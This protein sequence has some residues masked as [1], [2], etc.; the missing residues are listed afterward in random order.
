MS[1]SRC[2]ASREGQD[3]RSGHVLDIRRAIN[4]LDFSL[5]AGFAQLDLAT[6]PSVPTLASEPVTGDLSADGAHEQQQKEEELR[7]C[8]KAAY[9]ADLASFHDSELSRNMLDRPVVRVSLVSFF[10]TRVLTSANRQLRSKVWDPLPTTRWGT[11]FYTTH[12]WML[13][14]RAHTLETSIWAQ[15]FKIA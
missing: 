14:C 8:R 3:P 10:E 13:H 12:V 4:S 15:P 9:D 1:L 2:I 7:R 6:D 5:T 11:L